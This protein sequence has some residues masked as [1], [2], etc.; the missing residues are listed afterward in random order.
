[1]TRSPIGKVLS[2]MRQ[3]RVRALLMGGQACILY[4]AAEFSRDIDLAVAADEKNLERLR[5][6]LAALKAEPVYVPDLNKKVLERGHACHFRAR[7]DEAN[8]LRI[9]VMAVL[10]GCDSFPV[11]W[12]RRQRLKLPGIGSV[13]VLALPDLVLAKKTQRDKDWA[14]LR[15]LVEVDFHNRP[16]KPATRQI[17]F[18]LREVRTPE[19]LMEI[20]RLY[21]GSARRLAKIRPALRWAIK[22]HLAKV[23]DALRAEEKSVRTEDRAYWQPLREELFQWRQERRNK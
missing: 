2:A 4:G 14:M 23:E 21:P 19:L 3:H 13:P 18:W 15:R 8:G 1:L 10:R 22:G 5:R 6:A 12:T 17:A 7:I 9:D 20:C 16:K 11:L